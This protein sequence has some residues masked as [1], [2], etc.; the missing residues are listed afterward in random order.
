MIRNL[1]DNRSGVFDRRISRKRLISF[2][3]EGLPDTAATYARSP[4]GAGR[5]FNAYLVRSFL[6]LING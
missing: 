6:P 1:A 4:D 2:V 3:E 5:I